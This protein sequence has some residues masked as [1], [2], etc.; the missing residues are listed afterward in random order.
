M[1]KNAKDLQPED[2]IC[3]QQILSVDYDHPHVTVLFTDNSTRVMWYTD[4]V[5]VSSPTKAQEIRN[6]FGLFG[7]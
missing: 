2:W 3:G 7:S 5:S 1:I 6:M 4:R